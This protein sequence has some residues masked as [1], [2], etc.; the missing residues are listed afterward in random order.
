MTR[1]LKRLKSR[2]SVQ[3]K[4]A[5][6]ADHFSTSLMNFL[7]ANFPLH[8]SANLENKLAPFPMT[9]LMIFNLFHHHVTIPNIKTG[10]KMF[11]LI[12]QTSWAPSRPSFQFPG[13]L[14]VSHCCTPWPA[15]ITLLITIRTN[16]HTV[17][18][19]R[20]IVWEFVLMVISST[21]PAMCFTLP[22]FSQTLPQMDCAGNQMFVFLPCF[23]KNHN[24]TYF[25]MTRH[26]E[27]LRFWQ[28]V[29]NS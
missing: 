11:Q 25:S 6:K 17:I 7:W 15:M 22:Y 13:F 10:L 18:P 4:R 28:F 2:I 9:Q 23:S 24:W 26:L 14:C 20:I 5:L 1:I 19:Y 29:I 27:H 21:S 12:K 3:I 16:S 8:F